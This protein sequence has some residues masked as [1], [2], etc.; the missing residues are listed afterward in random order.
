MLMESC[1]C[2][3]QQQGI[4]NAIQPLRKAK[5]LNL[6]QIKEVELNDNKKRYR[7]IVVFNCK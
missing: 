6:N 2:Q 4:K 1:N 7:Q 3:F 5:V